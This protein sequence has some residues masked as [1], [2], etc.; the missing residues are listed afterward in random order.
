MQQRPTQSNKELCFLG[1]RCVIVFG[2]LD[3]VS[4]DG[5]FGAFPEAAAAAEEEGSGAPIMIVKR[6]N[7]TTVS[8]IQKREDREGIGRLNANKMFFLSS[9]PNKQK[10][11]ACRNPVQYF[12]SWMVWCLN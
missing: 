11:L 5:A 3:V 8:R 4:F 2:V 9:P 7:L 10:C 12:E 1:L 6:E